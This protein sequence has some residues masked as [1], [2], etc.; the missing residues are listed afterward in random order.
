MS[1]ANSPLSSYQNTSFRYAEEME[2]DVASSDALDAGAGAAK[3]SPGEVSIEAQVT[4]GDAI[5]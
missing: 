5:D 2:M 1:S 3:V 4:V